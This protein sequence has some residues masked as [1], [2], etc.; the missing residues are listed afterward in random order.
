MDDVSMTRSLH[1][2]GE[3]G[4]VSYANAIFELHLSYV[5]C[6]TVL[7]PSILAIAIASS[8]PLSSFLGFGFHPI[9]SSR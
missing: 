6:V 7:S 5:T 9:P 2:P 3:G 1:L 8:P 4:S